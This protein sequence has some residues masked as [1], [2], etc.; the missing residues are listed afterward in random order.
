MRYNNLV[1]IYSKYRNREEV[2][3]MLDPDMLY[4][5]GYRKSQFLL[6]FRKSTNCWRDERLWPDEYYMLKEFPHLTSS[7]SSRNALHADSLAKYYTTSM[8]RNLYAPILPK[9][10]YPHLARINRL[11]HPDDKV[12]SIEQRVR[13][14]FFYCAFRKLDVARALLAPVADHPQLDPEGRKLFITL[15][16]DSFKDQREYVNYLIGQ[17]ASLGQREWC[18]IWTEGKYLSHLLLED[19]KLKA[20]Y[21]CNCQQERN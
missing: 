9:E 6:H 14:A 2:W 5:K 20:F 11:F 1:F 21:N 12:L 3:H 13:L 10:I 16:A 7:G 17:Y 15:R 18:S 19:Q 8:I 4:C